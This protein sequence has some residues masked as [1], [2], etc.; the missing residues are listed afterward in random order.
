MTWRELQ[1]EAARILTDAGVDSPEADARLLAEHVAGSHPILAPDPTDAQAHEYLRLIDQRKQRV[2]LQHLTGV[3][4]FRNIELP[5]E[6]GVFIVRPE[7]EIVA[8]AAIDAARAAG[9]APL[10]VDL[11]TGSGAIAIAVADEV[12]GARIV[13]VELED[14]AYAAAS[15]NAAPYGIDVRQG[16]ARTACEDLLG[17]VDVV[18]SNPPY[19]PPST[20]PAEVLAD[21]HAALWGG[22]DDGLDLPGALVTRAR[23]LLKPGG[24]LIM[25]HDESQ[26]PALVACARALGMTAT[27]GTDLGGRPRYLHAM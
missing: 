26:G 24:V 16:D 15:T 2:P 6:P 17:T 8:G 20:V 3:M 1:R 21:P 22:G 12:P 25:E 9:P 13:A 14:N 23:H 5:A 18:V 19:V 7:T 27:T 4:H 10:V 11:C